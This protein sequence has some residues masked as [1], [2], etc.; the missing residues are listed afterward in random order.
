MWLK[1]SGSFCCIYQNS[2]SN[3]FITQR[4]K[5]RNYTKNLAHRN[6][7][8]NVSYNPLSFSSFHSNQVDCADN[9]KWGFPGLNV[10][11]LSCSS[12]FPELTFRTAF[13]EPRGPEVN[14]A[15]IDQVMW[16]WNMFPWEPGDPQINFLCN[17]DICELR[18][19]KLKI[20]Q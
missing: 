7:L 5:E 9:K 2:G 20:K 4:V 13:Q 19:G 3:T 18:S 16:W 17:P 12:Q 6:S 15:K 1:L 14:V 10:W 11:G 8:I